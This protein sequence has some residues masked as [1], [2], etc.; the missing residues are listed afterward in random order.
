M[1]RTQPPRAARVVTRVTETLPAGHVLRDAGTQLAQLF[2]AE[3]LARIKVRQP[4]VATV[5]RKSA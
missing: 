3:L 4:A 1:S 2:G 5:E